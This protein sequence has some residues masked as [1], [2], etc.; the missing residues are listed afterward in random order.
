[1]RRGGDRH[2]KHFASRS[3]TTNFNFAPSWKQTSKVLLEKFMLY[4]L[5]LFVC[6]LSHRKSFKKRCENNHQ[7]CFVRRNFF[8]A[9]FFGLCDVSWRRAG[10]RGACHVLHSNW[11]LVKRI[12]DSLLNLFVQCNNGTKHY[13][14]NTFHIFRWSRVEERREIM[15]W[16]FS[17]LFS[18]ALLFR[19][20]DSVLTRMRIREL[21]RGC[22]CLPIVSWRELVFHFHP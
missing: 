12:P 21:I 5:E 8:I 6:A 22:S 16:H 2:E 20:L 1:M 14:S 3:P 17:E 18:F 11:N 10:N 13:R 4:R 9:Y 15:V 19:S 7:K